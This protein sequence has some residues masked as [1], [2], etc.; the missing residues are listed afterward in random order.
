MNVISF[1]TQKGGTGKS[2][3]AVSLAVTAEA[4]GERVCILDLD[5]QGTSRDWYQTRTAETPAV[6]DHNQAGMLPETLTKLRKAGYTL[7]I[8]DT[9][10]IDSHGT[11]GAMQTANLCLI[12]VRP[13]EAD[14]KATMPT[15]AALHGMGKRFALVVNQASTNRQARITS[16]VIMRL[17][18]NG[19]VVPVPIA[20]R[21]DHQYAYALG[22]G[23]S[24]YAPEGKAA[25]EIAD[26]WGWCKK[27]LEVNHEQQTK[28][29]A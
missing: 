28:R 5:P 10:G 26:L 7:V 19:V 12:P 20:Q 29:R 21:I 4:A 11:R 9:P 17:S 6:L 14:M 27:Q 13:S 8:I 23:V 1:V 22:Q 2:H 3:L 16:A 18:S 15:V 24:E 25:E